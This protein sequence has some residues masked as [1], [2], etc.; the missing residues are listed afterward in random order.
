MSRIAFH[1]CSSS[2]IMC[3]LIG[4]N[5]LGEDKM[6]ADLKAASL[7]GT[8]FAKIIVKKP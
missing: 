5:V 3:V 1:K 2:F 6:S 4:L 8:L 7:E